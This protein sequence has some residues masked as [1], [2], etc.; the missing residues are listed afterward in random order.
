M[1]KLA[2][3]DFDGIHT[4]D[5]VLNRLRSQKEYLIDL[6]DACVVERGADGK[7]N[8]KQAGNLTARGAVS[9]GRP[10]RDVGG[11]VRL[12]FLNPVAAMAIGAMTGAG[13]LLTAVGTN[14][15][16]ASLTM[17]L[18]LGAGPALLALKTIRRNQRRQLR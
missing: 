10:E 18:L 2:V 6:E 4:A 5:E 16:A 8:I 11:S 13:C 14:T 9:G 12:L 3:F 15:T 1:S 7:V 17:V